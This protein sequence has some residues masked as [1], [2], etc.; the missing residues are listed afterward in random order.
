MSSVT[1]QVLVLVKALLLG[2]T[3]AGQSVDRGRVDPFSTDELPALNVRRGPTDEA[4][5]ADGRDHV[6]LSFDVDA[7]VRGADWET[8][9]DALQEEVYAVLKASTDLNTLVRGLRRVS[10]D[11]TAES[12]DGVAGRITA[13]FQCQFLQRRG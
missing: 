7:E 4:A 9:A 12:A 5:W 1:E 8:L 2:A 10:T 6:T 3:S 13:R 11:P